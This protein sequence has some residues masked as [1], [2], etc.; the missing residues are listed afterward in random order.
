[1]KSSSPAV[2]VIIP[3]YNCSDYLKQAINSV[4]MQSFSDWELIIVDNNSEDNTR[5]IVESYSDLRISFFSVKNEGIIAASRNLGLRLARGEWVAFLDADDLWYENKLDSCLVHASKGYEVVYHPM[6]LLRSRSKWF[7]RRQT[8][9]WQVDKPVFKDLLIRGNP[10]PN[11]SIFLK[12]SLLEKIGHIDEEPEI[13]TA[14]D[15]NTWIQVSKFTDQFICHHISLGSY[16]LHG[17]NMSSHFDKTVPLAK[18]IYR[19]LDSLNKDDRR[20]ANALLAYVRGQNLMA[21]KNYEKAA[22]EFSFAIFSVHWGLLVQ[23]FLFLC[24]CNIFKYFHRQKSN[25]LTG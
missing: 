9:T 13:V 15:F 18:V 12:R 24:K 19:H 10:I 16:R 2:S 4:I 20:K 23:S 25:S 22:H 7:F 6:D 11:S 14:E 5:E 3:S 8:K 21:H 17:S 1:M